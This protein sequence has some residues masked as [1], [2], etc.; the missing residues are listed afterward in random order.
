MIYATTTEL[1]YLHV[2][3]SWTV[4]RSHTLHKFKMTI[5]KDCLLASGSLNHPYFKAKCLYCK[6]THCLLEVHDLINEML[7]IRLGKCQNIFRICP[8]FQIT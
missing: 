7:K 3:L 6:I 5:N 8:C 1:L 2:S 4:L